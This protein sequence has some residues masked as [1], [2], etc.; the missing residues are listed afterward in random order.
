M[1]KLLAVVAVLLTLLTAAPAALADTPIQVVLGI[2]QLNLDAPPVIE[3]GTLFVPLRPMAEAL[4]FKVEYD[5]AEKR[6][7]LSNGEKVVELWVGVTKARSGGKDFA[8]TT[9]PRLIGNR[10]MIPSELLEQQLGAVVTWNEKDRLLY[11]RRGNE[12]ARDL[13]GTAQA[14]NLANPFADQIAKG[15]M[16]MTMKMTGPE[17]PGGVVGLD[18]PMTIDL[19]IYNGEMLMEMG[20]QQQGPTGQMSFSTR[21]AFKDG[22]MYMLIPGV[23]QWLLAGEG[24]LAEALEAN[25]AF[26]VADTSLLQGQMLEGASITLGSVEGSGPD[27]VARIDVNLS[28]AAINSVFDE[29]LSSMGALSADVPGLSMKAVKFRMS[30]WVDM[31]TAKTERVTMEM[32]LMMSAQGENPISM[33]MNMAADI[34]Y[35][36]VSQPIQ[37]PDLS[38]AIKPE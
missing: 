9:A 19:H 26:G 25:S 15:K 20:G 6:I 30:Q 37:F 13:F 38:G 16:Q 36:H 14:V 12:Y 5:P 3:D 33:T 31:S 4:G 22:K 29:L 2:S 35:S 18:M 32:G 17:I 23:E 11:V 8:L 28:P 21:M 24:S 27:K 10:T 1:R 7:A 34:S